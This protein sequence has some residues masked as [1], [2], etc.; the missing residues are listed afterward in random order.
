MMDEKLTYKELVI[1]STALSHLKSHF[2]KSEDYDMVEEITMLK[3]K[4]DELSEE[5]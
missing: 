1:I 5:I 4:I 2:K 3:Y